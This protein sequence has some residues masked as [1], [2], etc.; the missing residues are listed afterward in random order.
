MALPKQTFLPPPENQ[1]SDGF[2]DS[3]E[4]KKEI[5]G[6]DNP[7]KEEKASLL[8]PPSFPSPQENQG[9]PFFK[10]NKTITIALSLILALAYI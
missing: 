2:V 7:K 3:A 5:N 9:V 8:N 10:K 4:S 6:Q 1:P